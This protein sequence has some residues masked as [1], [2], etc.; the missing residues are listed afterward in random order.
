MTAAEI[1][2]RGGS[3]GLF[4]YDDAAPTNSFTPRL[5][6]LFKAA[7]SEL[8]HPRDEVV[9]LLV[10]ANTTVYAD[11]EQHIVE[12]QFMRVPVETMPVGVEAVYAE[13]GGI[14]LGYK[15]RV[16]AA[17]TLNGKVILGGY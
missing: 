5:V 17:I 1:V 11:G 13:R 10:P 7:A 4:V 9:K 12:G 15:G 2:E 16:V 14:F 8:L 6:Q 3:V